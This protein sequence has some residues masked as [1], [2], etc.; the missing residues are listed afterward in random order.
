MQKKFLTNLAFILFVNLT[1]KPIYVLGIET[2][3]QNHTQAGNF[4]VYFAIFN[5]CFILSI[6]LDFGITN[7]NNRNIA[8]N[9]HLLTKHFSA[10]FTLKMVLALAYLVVIVVGGLL[11]GYD[12]RLM[13]LLLV[14]G[15]NM[16]LL[17]FIN[18][19]RSNLAGLHLFKTDSIISILD[20]LILIVLCIFMLKMKIFKRP[21]GIMYFVYA[22]TFSYLTSAIAV[23]IVVL[24]KTHSFKIFWNWPFSLMILKKSLP[25]ATLS[26]LMSFYNR[27]DTVMIERILPAG[28]GDVQSGI[29][30]QAFRMLDSANMIAFLTAGMLLPIFSRMLKYKESV[31]SL[32]KLISTLLIAFALVVGISCFFYSREFMDLIYDQHIEES[33]K[34]FGLIMLSF[35]AVSTT[36]IFGTLLT[37]NGNLRQLNIM[38]AFGMVI[39]IT[40]NF[41]LIPKLNAYGSAISSL[42]TQFSAAII[43]VII[44]QRIFKFKVNYRLI[45][46]FI[47][48]TIGV[49]SINYAATIILPFHWMINFVVMTLT[50]VGWAFVSGMISP[51]AIF[52]LLKYG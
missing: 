35:I 12:S 40:L 41:I 23:F 26:L 2:R 51:K 5:F 17:F 50:C 20:R 3:V 22:Q 30:A 34:I 16:F 33:A 43:Q 7:F 8:Q 10:I 52:R 9:S 18:Y 24:R 39:N 25:F 48:F 14:V 47:M 36:Y 6:I 11:I 32:V 21:D 15:F 42:I 4:G 46:T 13:K 1:I 37:A 19:M 28:V 38:A 27:I 49:I 29:Y 45:N 44:A 31:E